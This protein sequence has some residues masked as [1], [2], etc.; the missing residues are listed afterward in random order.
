LSKSVGS[1]LS[2]TLVSHF[3]PVQVPLQSLLHDVNVCPGNGSLSLIDENG[4]GVDL[5]K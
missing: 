2:R 1:G 3:T 5:Q 4:I